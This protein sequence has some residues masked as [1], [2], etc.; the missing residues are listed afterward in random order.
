MSTNI[1]DIAHELERAIRNQPDYQAL[2]AM[3]KEIAKD[4]KAKSILDKHTAFQKEMQTLMQ[5]GQMPDQSVHKRMQELN[6][7]IQSNS[8]VLEYFNKQQQFSIYIA[9]VE[10]IIFKPLQE[11]L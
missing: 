7:E 11:L 3:K 6:K 5:S 8:L 4:A 2:Q 9:D 1:Y 10:K